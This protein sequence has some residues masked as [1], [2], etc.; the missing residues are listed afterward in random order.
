MW[1]IESLVIIGLLVLAC[2][3]RLRSINIAGPGPVG[4]GFGYSLN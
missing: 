3:P 2:L 1:I 4:R